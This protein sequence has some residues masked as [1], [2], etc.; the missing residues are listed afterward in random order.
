MAIF[1]YLVRRL[2]GNPF[3]ERKFQLFFF[4]VFSRPLQ[5]GLTS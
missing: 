5:A 1:K 3:K 2:R 4:H